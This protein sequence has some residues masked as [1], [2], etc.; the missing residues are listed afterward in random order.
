LILALAPLL[1]GSV[2][3]G[4][5]DIGL[6]VLPG[7]LM[8]CAWYCVTCLAICYLLCAESARL[9]S[10]ALAVGLLVNVTLNYCLAPRFA[11]AGVVAA[12]AIANALT[13]LLVCRLSTWHG[14]RWDA[15]TVRAAFLP[16]CLLLGGLPALAVLMVV[17]VAGQSWM[18]T[19]TER[20]WLR[21]TALRWIDRAR[22]RLPHP[23]H[24]NLEKA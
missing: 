6:H 21:G 14:M 4:R 2:L 19:A 9:A 10:V 3:H 1:F 22:S 17:A 20:D 23:A 18:F 24:W 16:L 7:T 12:T 8:Y 15:G 5:Y 13:L 11:L